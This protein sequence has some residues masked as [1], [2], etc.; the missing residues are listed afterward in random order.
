MGHRLL[1]MAFKLPCAF[2]LLIPTVPLDRLYFS[3]SEITGRCQQAELCCELWGGAQM[4]SSC[5]CQH[6]VLPHQRS[7]ALDGLFLFDIGMVS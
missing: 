5:G 6:W 4:A 7:P 2:E 1:E 3:E